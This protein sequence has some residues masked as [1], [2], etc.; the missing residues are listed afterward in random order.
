MA[1]YGL[2]KA[3]AKGFCVTP[4]LLFIQFQSESRLSATDLKTPNLR[5]WAG[6][7]LLYHPSIAT[8]EARRIRR[9]QM[10]L[11]ER[12]KA[13]TTRH[14]TV[15]SGGGTGSHIRLESRESRRD[16]EGVS[17][18][19][20]WDEEEIVLRSQSTLQQSAKT[21]K[22]NK[23]E[24]DNRLGRL[25][26]ILRAAEGLFEGDKEAA[27][28]WLT[29]P[30]RGLGYKRPIDLLETSAESDSVIGLIECLERGIFV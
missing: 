29:H 2:L 12:E 24:I 8:V 4:Q 22:L 14:G 1:Q 21:G 28:G 7:F 9:A 17:Y 23:N 20:R 11:K 26:K 10:S 13:G 19:L 3:Y 15:V 18:I 6:L 5:R 25:G 27:I 16:D 30:V